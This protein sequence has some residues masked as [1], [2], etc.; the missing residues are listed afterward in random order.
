MAKY[1]RYEKDPELK[2]KV[3]NKCEAALDIELFGS[4]YVNKDGYKN[5]CKA[6]DSQKEKE[7]YKLKTEH[8]KAK[9]RSY[10]HNNKETIRVS[11][12]EA[13]K[14]KIQNDPKYK[15]IRNLR[16]RLW[17]A[18]KN[19]D[20]TKTSTF[21]EYIGCVP[22][23]LFSHIEK[24]FTKEM[25]W[26]NY[27]KI[28]EIDHIE[29]L[30]FAVDDQDLY[31]RSHYTNLKPLLVKD[32]RQKYNHIVD[33]SNY[34][35]V[36]ID[37]TSYNDFLK[38]NHY[39]STHP[40][41]SVYYGLFYNAVLVGVAS[42]G[43]PSGPTVAENLVGKTMKE[44]VLELKRFA[45]KDNKPNE[46]SYFLSRTLKLLPSKHFVITYADPS[47]GHEGGLYKACN[48]IYLGMTQKKK[49]YS[50]EGKENLHPRT[51]VNYAKDDVEYVDRVQKHRYVFIT[52]NG[53][54]K[55]ALEKYIQKETGS[56]DPAS[57]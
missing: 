29:P 40:G 11:R 48:F 32:N 34:N 42:Y 37:Y 13:Q 15:T 22:D 33:H 26:D 50:V 18:L 5:I 30:S 55:R 9:T 4:A 52:G 39:L 36:P 6:C 44:F 35:I 56:E 17:Y 16:N 38:N 23:Q 3:C 20:W 57:I 54:T 7:R 14:N 45:L 46:G 10:Y 24:Q 53:K 27:G 31:R 43:K 41:A 28:W 47:Q 1:K 12:R 49:N 2:F 51:L 8:I 19:K 25:S 21:S